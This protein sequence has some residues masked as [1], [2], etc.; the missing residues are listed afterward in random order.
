[1]L[2]IDTEGHE[3]Q[4]LQSGKKLLNKTKIIQVEIMDKKKLFEK[5]FIKRDNFLKKYNFKLLKIK[6]IFS[7]SMLSN[8]KA[9]DTLYIN[10]SL[11]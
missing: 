9:I 1:L 11:C 4:V 8:I 10:K 2:K 6:N 7:V 5:K 3:F